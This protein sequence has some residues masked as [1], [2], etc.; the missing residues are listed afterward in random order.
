MEA[1]ADHLNGELH[2]AYP[3]SARQYVQLRAG[4]GVHEQSFSHEINLL[5]PDREKNVLPFTEL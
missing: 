3:V 2:L 4:N 1:N 5:L